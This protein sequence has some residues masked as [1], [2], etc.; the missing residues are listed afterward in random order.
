MTGERTP[1]AEAL[2]LQDAQGFG[3]VLILN[4][5]EVVMGAVYRDHLEA[6]SA[7]A[8]VGTVMRL[9][10]SMAGRRCHR[11]GGPY[12]VNQEQVVAEQVVAEQV[13]DD[14]ARSC[15]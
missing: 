3:P 10:V 12:F 14:A 6:A 2:R 5:A 11:G 15:R 13:L 4:Q 8:E 9:G 1:G 7:E